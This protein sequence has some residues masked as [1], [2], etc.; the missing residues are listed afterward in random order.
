MKRILLISSFLT[1]FIA[2]FALNADSLYL[3]KDYIGAMKLYEEQLK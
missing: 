3:Q 2:G 1:I